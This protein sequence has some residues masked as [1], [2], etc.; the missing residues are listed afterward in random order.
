M[1]LLPASPILCREANISPKGLRSRRICDEA[2]SQPPGTIFYARVAGYPFPTIEA[3]FFSGLASR[4]L[5]CHSSFT[6][7]IMHELVSV[8]ILPH[9]ERH[10]Y[11]AKQSHIHNLVLW[12]VL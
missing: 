1:W 8:D 6:G 9:S 7:F 11:Q 12:N 5:R 10:G 2:S 3:P 4:P